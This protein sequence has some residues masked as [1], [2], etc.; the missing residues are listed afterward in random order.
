MVHDGKQVLL[1]CR[2]LGQLRD[3]VR[4][5]SG[6]ERIC[7][8]I[9]EAAEAVVDYATV[10]SRCNQCFPNSVTI[11]RGYVGITVEACR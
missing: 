4:E 1:V 2:R 9:V 8:G 3:V 11:H 6:R 7:E 5:V 10:T